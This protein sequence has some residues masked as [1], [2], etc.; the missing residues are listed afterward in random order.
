MPDPARH[1]ALPYQGATEFL[2]SC[3]SLA[4]DA[5][6]RDQRLILLAAEARLADIREAL[7]A[8]GDD[9]TY[10]ATDRHVRNPSR[11]TTLLD[12]VQATGNGRRSVAIT[13]WG[14][15]G[16]SGAVFAETQLAE[17]LLNIVALRAWPLDVVCLYDA[18]L[19]D[20]GG[21]AGIRRVHPFVRGEPDN[22]EYQ[23]ELATALFAEVLGAGPDGS[24][25]LEVGPQDLS[26]VRR[27]VRAFGV[28]HGLPADRVEDLVIAANEIVTNSVRHGGGSGRMTLWEQAESVV[29]EVVDTGH[30]TDPLAGRLAPR[31]DA[32]S[33]RGLWLA[34]HLCDLVQVRSSP[35]GTV[36]RLY[37]DRL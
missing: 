17:S 12:S 23:P 9:L 4:E 32:P 7:G 30:I 36:V 33:G 1:E 2:P 31:P 29:C 14:L 26:R 20:G 16:R 22:A 34:N 24:E 37:V 18:T 19:L 8:N 21:L 5:Q 10:V 15:P 28:A 6:S 13:D 25:T 35:A 27:L 11:I 3:L